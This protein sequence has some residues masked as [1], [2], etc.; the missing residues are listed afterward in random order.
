MTT[1]E[2]LEMKKE[3]QKIKRENDILPILRW[4]IKLNWRNKKI[5]YFCELFL[6]FSINLF[7]GPK[8]SMQ[9]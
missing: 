3:I 8:I 1:K 4:I 9:K 5:N 7:N 6:Q 2:I